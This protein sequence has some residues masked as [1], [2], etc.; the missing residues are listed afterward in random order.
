MS[1]ERCGTPFA[2]SLNVS[3]RGVIHHALAP[4]T[5]PSRRSAG[6]LPAGGLGV[7]WAHSMRP[8]LQAYGVTVQRN[9]AGGLGVPPSSLISPKSGGRGLMNSHETAWWSGA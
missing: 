5:L 7:S 9:A 2:R 8:G 3:R 4:S 1:Q 6:T